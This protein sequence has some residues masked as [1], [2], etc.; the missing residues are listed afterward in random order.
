LQSL[1][2][3][4]TKRLVILFDY[5]YTIFSYVINLLIILIA[6]FYITLR[7]FVEYRH[8][9]LYYVYFCTQ[10]ENR[11]IDFYHKWI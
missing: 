2:K 9:I 6:N 11:Y 8:I 5:N 1:I 10:K 4:Y 3:C 7:F